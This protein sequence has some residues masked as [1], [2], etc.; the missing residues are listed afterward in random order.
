MN[1]GL[2]RMDKENTE[3]LSHSRKHFEEFH[4]H[5]LLNK[6]YHFGSASV[7]VLLQCKGPEK[8]G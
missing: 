2:R 1:L 6:N 4:L 5:H 8:Q 7:A 3:I